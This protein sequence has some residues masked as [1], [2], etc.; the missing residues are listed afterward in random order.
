[1]QPESMLLT[2][3]RD[4]F[5]E[6]EYLVEKHRAASREHGAEF[7]RARFS[8]WVANGHLR[9]GRRG[10]A[11]RT[12][13]RG[14]ARYRDVGAAARAA[15]ALLGPRGSRV[16]R[17]AVARLPGPRPVRLEVDEPVWLDLYRRSSRTAA[18]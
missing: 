4:V 2:D 10:L 5:L 17:A 12:Y 18:E 16:G 7:D 11:S 9:A 15:G 13:L 3:R 14:A 1:M 8:R 6:L